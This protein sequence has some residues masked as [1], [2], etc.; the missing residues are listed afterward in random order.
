MIYPSYQ[1]V[2][3]KQVRLSTEACFTP[4]CRTKPPPHSRR[5]LGLLTCFGTAVVILVVVV[6]ST[7]AMPSFRPTYGVACTGPSQ[8]VTTLNTGGTFSQSGLV[9]SATAGTF[10]IPGQSAGPV[11]LGGGVGR[12]T[13]QEYFTVDPS[14]PSCY[15][16]TS[17]YPTATATFTFSFSGRMNESITCAPGTSADVSLKLYANV[18]SSGSGALFATPPSTTPVNSNINCAVGPTSFI[19]TVGGATI[20]TGSFAV[21]SGTQYGFYAEVDIHNDVSVGVGGAGSSS[22]NAFQ[23]TLTSV[24]CPACP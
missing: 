10:S 2:E 9:A 7:L 19:S 21:A 24:S 20:T 15:Q 1:P 12:I 11:G 4:T 22:E 14:P 8:S 18:F 23:V 13:S 6:P 5:A 17:S 16:P 3:T